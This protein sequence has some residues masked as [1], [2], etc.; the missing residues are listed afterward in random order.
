MKFSTMFL[1]YSTSADEIDDT[2]IVKLNYLEKITGEIFS[3]EAI[4]KSTSWKEGWSE[5]F[6]RNILRMKNSFE[7]CGTHD[8]EDLDD[9]LI[10]FDISNPCGA[11]NELTTG[12]AKWVNQYISSCRGQK[13]K[14]H[15]KNR[16]KKWN[17]KFHKGNGS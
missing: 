3:S 5:R 11:L 13:K 15:H 7:R 14:S 2:A 12:Y 16:L 9:M 1:A 17:K 10:D 8:G 4:N 6:G